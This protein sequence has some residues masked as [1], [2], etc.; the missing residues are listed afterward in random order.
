MGESTF[1]KILEDS[2]VLVYKTRGVSMEPMLRQERDIIII[3]PKPEGR[4]RKYDVPLY[5]RGQDYVLH[6]IIAVRENGYEILG[7]NTYNVEYGI[8]D[9][10]IIGVLSEFVRKGK[11]YSVT[12]RGYIVYSRVWCAIYPLRAGYRRIKSRMFCI[13]GR[14]LRALNLRKQH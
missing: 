6:R 12:D 5:R 7:D 2:G 13:G 9:E 10:D 3:R 4:L 11:K 8:T 1:E 14:I